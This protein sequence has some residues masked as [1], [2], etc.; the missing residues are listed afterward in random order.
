M[1]DS[2]HRWSPPRQQPPQVEGEEW[3]DTYQDDTPI[4]DKVWPLRTHASA[5]RYQA[6]IGQR[7]HGLPARQS[8]IPPRR[9]APHQRP[10]PAWWYEH[11]PL[12]PSRREASQ[13]RTADPLERHPCAHMLSRQVSTPVSRKADPMQQ[14]LWGEKGP[15]PR[16]KRSVI[17]LPSAP[18]YS[19]T[20]ANDCEL[21][22]HTENVWD[23]AGCS[24]CLDCGVKIFCPHCIS[25]HPSDEHAVPVLCEMHSTKAVSA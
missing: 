11:E 17:P 21:L 4:E 13:A 6:T 5:V 16:R 1:S 3:Y 24:S 20:G 2:Q 18:A 25:R 23:L 7:R 12:P 8:A 10:W 19:L 9:T 15:R 14:T 22:G